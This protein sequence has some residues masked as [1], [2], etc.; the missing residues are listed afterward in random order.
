MI[1]SPRLL[2]GLLVCGCLLWGEEQAPPDVEPIQ[3]LQ[4]PRNLRNAQPPGAVPN[5]PGAGG[6][7]H[8]PYNPPLT[9]RKIQ[10]AIA[11]ACLFLRGGQRKDGGWGDPGQTALCALALL[12]A[13]GDP[14]CDDG[15]AKALSWLLKCYENPASLDNTYV[16]GLTANVWEYA[17]RKVPYEKAYKDALKN[18]FDYLLKGLGEKKKAWRYSQNSTDWDNSCTQYGV[19]GLWAAQRAGFEPGEEIWKRLSQHFQETQSQDGGWHYTGGRDARGGTPNMATAG[20]ASLFLVFDMCYGKNC[21][22]AKQPEVFAGGEAAACLKAIEKGMSWL[23]GN[24][25]GGWSDG[26]FLY[27]IE[28]TGVAS[29]RKYIGGIDWFRQ[30]ADAVLRAQ[31]SHG[32]I[33]LGHWGGAYGSTCFAVLFLVYGGAPVAYNKL[34]YGADKDW[35]LNPRDLANLGKHLWS[36]YERPLNWNAVSIASPVSEF[37]APVLFISGSKALHLGGQEAAKLREYIQRGGTIFAEGSDRSEAFVKS[38]GEVFGRLFPEHRLERLADNHPVYT[39]LKQQW[40]NRPPLH[41][42]SDGARTFFFVSDGYLSGDWQSNREESDAFKLGLNLLFYATDLGG[43][44]GKFS[45]GLPDTPAAKER[46]TALTVARLKLSGVQGPAWNAAP[47]CWGQFADYLKHVAG[48]K[49]EERPAVAPGAGEL[50]DLRLLH[51]TGMGES[52]KFT[53]AERQAL[54]EYVRQGGTLL[55][56]A[57]AGDVPFAASVRRELEATFGPLAPLD[58]SEHLATGQFEGGE[59]LTRGLRL[60]LP[61]RKQLRARKGL[62]ESLPLEVIR[63]GKRPAVLF[64]ELDL[65][66]AMAGI[67]NFQARGFKPASARR[68][69][70]NLAAYV[71]AE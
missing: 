27:G 58:P 45:T 71:T 23:G 50:K 4:I 62:P 67:E 33:A 15:L 42:A 8:R 38:A 9:A 7:L 32:G 54:K 48:V 66:G 59:D 44:E 64:S 52:P 20:L 26:Y 70:A 5:A 35:N 47:R 31:Q 40:Q 29:G 22:S 41:G 19:L 25:R 56:D 18:D 6:M 37:E 69:V 34:E 16:R 49:L 51:L 39:V 46:A 1:R 2:L 43:L 61:A 63:A 30:G 28:R 17:L 68:I 13:G 3:Q 14:T 24:H 11:D 21:Y 57:Y 36:A 53:D 10:T 12:A 65:T 60:K 55:V